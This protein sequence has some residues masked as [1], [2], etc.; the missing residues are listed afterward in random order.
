Q[1]VRLADVDGS[2]TTDIIYLGT[3][4]ITW[5][6]NRCGNSLSAAIEIKNFPPIDNLT[7]VQVLD[8]LGRG[9]SCIVW[10]SPLP[11]DNGNQIR[12]IDLIGQKPYLL[13]GVQNNMGGEQRM[14]YTA[15][16]EFYL[17]DK[18]NG[19]PWVTKLPFPVQTLSRVETYDYISG[20]RLI[21]R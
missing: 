19:T 12:Y 13:I 4:K 15:S 5:W 18:R 17:R 1:R 3:D 2:G 7:S 20:T 11:G 16:T 10:S 8:I 9:T 14:R 21:S 6:A